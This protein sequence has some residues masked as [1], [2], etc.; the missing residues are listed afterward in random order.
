MFCCCVSL[1]TF[2][3]SEPLVV[4]LK[5]LLCDE[6]WDSFLVSLTWWQKRFIKKEDFDFDVPEK[7]FVFK[8]IGQEFHPRPSLSFDHVTHEQQNVSN[9]LQANSSSFVSLSRPEIFS[10]DT[11]FNNDTAESQMYHFRFEKSRRTEISVTFQKGFTIGGKANFSIGVPK[12]FSE[13]TLGAEIQLQ[14][15]V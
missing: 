14:Y 4:D 13:G 1:P 5:K 9:R 2:K 11:V 12:I 15:Q 10:L 3:E 7:F 6:A 8:D